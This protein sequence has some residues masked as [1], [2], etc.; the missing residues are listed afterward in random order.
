MTR[1]NKGDR[2]REDTPTYPIG[3]VVWSTDEYVSVH[4]DGDSYPQEVSATS[5]RILLAKACAVELS[6]G[7]K[8][9]KRGGQD[10]V[11]LTAGATHSTV[12]FDH[13]KFVAEVENVRLVLLEKAP[14]P[15]SWDDIRPGDVVEFEFLVTGDV[16]KTTAHNESF[17]VCILGWSKHSKWAGKNIRLISITK[18]VKPL[19]TEPVVIALNSGVRA[20]RRERDGKWVTDSILRPLTDDEVQAIGWEVAS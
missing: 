4:W 15:P 3:T 10:G 6:V 9:H 12:R 16:I 17:G 8:V 1:Y 5:G 18:P 11:V 7:D 2:V 19:P 20:H 13:N 14:K